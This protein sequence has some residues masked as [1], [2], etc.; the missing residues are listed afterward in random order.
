MSLRASFSVLCAVFI[1][2]V[3]GSELLSIR[4]SSLVG[5]AVDAAMETLKAEH[6]IEYKVVTDGGS[7]DAIYK[8]ADGVVD[9][10][11]STRAMTQSERSI[12][13][14]FTFKEILVGRQ[15]VLVVVP[16][17]VWKSGVHALTREQF[18]RIYE[19]E[20]TNWKELGGED[21]AITFYNREAGRGVWDLFVIFIYGD[22]RKA[23]SVKNEVIA[24]PWDLRTAVEFNSGGIGLLEYSELQGSELHALGIKGDDGKIIEPTPHNISTG[25]YELSRP[26]LMITSRT[27]TGKLRE[28]VQFMTGP[29]GQ[30]FVK[31]SGHVTLAELKASAK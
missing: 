8:V 15:A 12:R 26:L 6:D 23:A 29:K 22:A 2:S 16:E 17:T 20:I 21:R 11:L 10:A 28:F 5:V 31:K 27:L 19:Q 13:P 1:A 25:R 4:G 14:D 9:F 30:E 7:T 18:R 24:L 3:H